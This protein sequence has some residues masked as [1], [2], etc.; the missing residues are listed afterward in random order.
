VLVLAG[1]NTG[2][3]NEALRD[4]ERDAQNTP[5]MPLEQATR[6]AQRYFPATPTFTPAPPL[7]PFVGVIAVTQI[8]NGD[9]SPQGSFASFPTDAGQIL[10]TVKLHG[11]SEGQIMTGIWAD[12]WGNEIGVVELELASSADPQ[13][14]AFPLQLSTDLPTGPYA[15][16]VFADEQRVGS[17]A[18]ALTA[19]GNAPQMY[20]DLPA[21]PQA[22]SATEQPRGRRTPTPQPWEQQNGDQQ[23]QGEWNQQEEWNQQSEG[24]GEWQQEGDWQE[25]GE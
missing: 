19:P 16:W 9:G 6:I 3:A 10:G 12:Q 17:V 20:P 4:R 15:L 25:Q 23:G 11:A 8:V 14:V 21:D 2:R 18:F 13:W 7:Y 5:V 24:E 22:S 1:C